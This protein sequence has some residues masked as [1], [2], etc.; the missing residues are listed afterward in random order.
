MK[1]AAYYARV[2]KECVEYLDP[3]TSYPNPPAEQYHLE[4]L[5]QDGIQ[6]GFEYC[7]GR[8]LHNL[9]VQ[10]CSSAPYSI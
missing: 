3:V 6:V 4:H 9:S 1:S 5:A 7:H 2:P 8:R 10:T